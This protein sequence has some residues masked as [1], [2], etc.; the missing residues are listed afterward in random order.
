[1]HTTFYI[2]NINTQ[3]EK[4]IFRRFRMGRATALAAALVGAD[5][6]KLAL[7]TSATSK[8]RDIRARTL[9]LRVHVLE[10]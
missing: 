5:L 4:T 9:Y 10:V 6:S 8:T 3:Y 2:V 7:L 1:M